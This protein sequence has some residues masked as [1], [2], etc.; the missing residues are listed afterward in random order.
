MMNV[1]TG[2]LAG[3]AVENAAT[4]A[5]AAATEAAGN[6]QN[7]MFQASKQAQDLTGKVVNKTT[8]VWNCLT[9]S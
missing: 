1:K 8:S 6:A 2:L 4:A 5:S 9:H 3:A 7:F